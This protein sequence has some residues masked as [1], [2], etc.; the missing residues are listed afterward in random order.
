MGETPWRFKSSLR[1]QISS[2]QTMAAL[3]EPGKPGFFVGEGCLTAV[4]SLMFCQGSRSQGFRRLHAGWAS[5][6]LGE[7]CL[8]DTTE[9]KVE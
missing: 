5:H 3:K 1:H 4:G 9:R 2:L 6:E 8:A 7:Y